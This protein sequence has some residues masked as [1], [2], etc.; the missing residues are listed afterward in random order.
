M[1]NENAKTLTKNRILGLLKEASD[2]LKIFEE[3]KDEK[4]LKFIIKLRQGAIKK[5]ESIPENIVKNK[6]GFKHILK[7]SVIFED[8]RVEHFEEFGGV[9]FILEMLEEDCYNI[10]KYIGIFKDKW[11]EDDRVI[12]NTL[13]KKKGYYHRFPKLLKDVDYAARIIEEIPEI[14]RM[15]INHYEGPNKKLMIAYLI[16]SRSIVVDKV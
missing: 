16:G 10:L 3:F 15:L 12:M 7:S 6:K 1:S 4:D 2:E 14:Y 8:M 11:K 9:E 13:K 5:L